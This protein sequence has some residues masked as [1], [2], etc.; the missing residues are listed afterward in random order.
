M[1]NIER[2]FSLPLNVM[3]I[4][5][6]W[7][8]VSSAPVEALWISNE[9]K[10]KISDAKKKRCWLGL[11]RRGEEEAM[12][13]E[14]QLLSQSFLAIRLKLALIISELASH[15]LG[16]PWQW[17]NFKSI[18]FA[19]WHP[20]ARELPTVASS[21]QKSKAFVLLEPG[22]VKRADGW[23]DVPSQRCQSTPIHL[24]LIFRHCS[25][26][27]SWLL[28]FINYQVLSQILIALFMLRDHRVKWYESIRYHFLY[29]CQS[30]HNDDASRSMRSA[31][32]WLMIQ[33]ISIY[34]LV[35]F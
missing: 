13:S 19:T 17:Q 14:V 18:D 9:F 28:M 15:R 33:D 12:E 6:Y 29:Q 11:G 4:P 7:V 20:V 31:R 21:R 22:R 1:A 25:A 23:L 27:L 35:S 26:H 32:I 30:W 8:R 34:F 10:R 24:I 3:V 2:S 5:F 16:H